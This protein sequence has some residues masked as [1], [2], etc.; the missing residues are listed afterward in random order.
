MFYVKID[1]TDKDRRSH[2]KYWRQLGI[3]KYTSKIDKYNEKQEL[4]S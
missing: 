1:S 3:H 4:K 2:L